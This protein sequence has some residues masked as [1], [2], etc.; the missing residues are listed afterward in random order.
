M[1]RSEDGIRNELLDELLMDNKGSADLT[2]KDGA[3]K[4]LTKA[5]V[6]FHH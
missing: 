3:L 1:R 5:L 2:G 6:A 4:Q